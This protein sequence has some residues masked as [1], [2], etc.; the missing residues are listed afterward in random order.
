MTPGP[1]RRV[2][3]VDI[4]SN[5]VR[6]FLCSGIGPDGPEGQRWTTITGLKRGAHL[7]RV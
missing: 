2:A 3:V 6:L 1:E 7:A 4:G 5:S